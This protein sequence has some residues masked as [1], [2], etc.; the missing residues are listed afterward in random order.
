MLSEAKN[1]TDYEIEILQSLRSFRM[2]IRSGGQK[3]KDR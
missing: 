3:D 2:T 1:L